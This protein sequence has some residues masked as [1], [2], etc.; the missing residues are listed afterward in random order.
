[1]ELEKDDNIIVYPML[2]EIDRDTREERLAWAR[3]EG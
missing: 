1:M 3:R 2:S